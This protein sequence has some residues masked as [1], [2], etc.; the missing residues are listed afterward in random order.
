MP[1]L[2]PFVAVASVADVPGQYILF[3]Q[4]RT[5]CSLYAAILYFVYVHLTM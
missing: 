2:L 3:T 1:L 4:E 5:H